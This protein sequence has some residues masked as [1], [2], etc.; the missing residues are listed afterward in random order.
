MP[1]N[2]PYHDLPLVLG[3]NTNFDP[4][5]Q[6]L[7]TLL[8][9]QNMD[10]YEEFRALS[11][12]PGSTKITATALG[13]PNQV[14]S[15]HQYEY[16][17]LDT[18][19][20]RKQLANASTILYDITS[21]TGVSIWSSPALQAEALSSVVMH[22]RIFLTSEN[23][24]A[25]V[26]GGVKYDGTNARRWGVVA[27]G[28]EPTVVQDFDATTGWSANS[29]NTVG[30][31][32]NS[33]DG[34]GSV[35]LTKVDTGGTECYMERTG[36]AAD[37]SASEI[38]YI[39]VYIPPGTL[40]DLEPS[41]DFPTDRSA[42]EIWLGD[43]GM[44]N[45]DEW[46]F[47]VGELVPG[48][49]LLSI[50]LTVPDD[51][52]GG[53]LTSLAAVD[54]IR[55][56]VNT[57]TAGDTF[58]NI[59]WDNFYR[60]DLGEPTA[61]TP[62][63]AG[64]V[65]G[66]VSY[67]CSFFTEYGVESNAGPVS[68]SVEATTAFATGTLTVGTEVTGDTFTVGTQVYTLRSSLTPT[69]NEVLIGSSSDDTAQYI[70]DAIN[71]TGDPGVTYASGTLANADCSA[72]VSGSVVTV[73]SKTV[74]TGGNSIA[75]AETGTSIS[76]SGSL[77]TG[78]RNG[79]QVSLSAVPTSSD[80]QVLG[81][82]IY[83][84]AE[85][86]NIFRFVGQID[87][88]TATDFTDDVANASLG[89]AT[90]PIAGDDQIDSSP[91]ERMRAV[92]VHETRVFG[93]SGDDPSILLISDVDSPEIFR[94]VDQLSVDE[95]LVGLRSHPLGLVLYGR[96]RALLLRGDGIS[97]PFRVDNLNPQLGANNFRCIVSALGQNVVLR[98]A[99]VFHVLDP[100][101]AWLINQGVYDQFKAA[102]SAQLSSAFLAHD[103]DRYR[104]LFFIGSSIQSYQYGTLGT[105]EITGDGPGVAPKD[106]R[107]GAW[108]TLDL[109]VIPTCAALVEQ[110][111]EKQELWFGA[112]DGHVYHLQDTAAVT[113]ADGGSTSAITATVETHPVP[114]G[115]EAGRGEPRYLEVRSNSSTGITWT[116][117]VT[118]LSEADGAT[119]GTSVV[120]VVCPAGQST[121]EVP[122]P[123]VGAI[124]AW[125]RVKL[126]NSSATE[127]GSV[128]GLRLYYISR[129]SR[130]STRSS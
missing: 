75:L 66:N 25:L 79:H 115:E 123:P 63:V 70:A 91:P 111:A 92:T 39:W 35:S 88:N 122:V 32:T 2:L 44:T 1:R 23:Q 85:G 73:T 101:D 119:L 40:Q 125:A 89:S 30:T 105:Q 54:T 29:T 82:R 46:A 118:V 74:G 78:G 26:T 6:G 21:G 60:V 99:E 45:R 117:T 33:R 12:V 103:E 120:S 108:T 14:E 19:R 76:I 130:R 24:F 57:A 97:S 49:N 65:T 81:R 93:I 77:L 96:T 59:L 121:V 36:L 129:S 68:N 34:G 112:T 87:D 127:V 37:L 107:I 72:T 8:S 64:N 7:K 90:V 9:C 48:W 67:R 62:S 50:T 52:N 51:D 86:D 41:A 10:S 128:R 20:T 106:L 69:A 18:T 102:S 17:A 11:K 13:S 80:P 27:P 16:T 22:D 71:G 42:I 56:I 4:R 43:A 55:L 5:S 126:T 38:A 3:V 31:S 113:Y 84:D 116:A 100:R 83:R 110:N 95:E 58:T 28:S 53:G 109:P 114:L 98:D 94:I 104:V 15:L 124:G 47:G 61:A